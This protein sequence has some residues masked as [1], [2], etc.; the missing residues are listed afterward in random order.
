MIRRSL[1]AAS[2]RAPAWCSVPSSRSVCAFAPPAQADSSE[3]TEH[4]RTFFNAGAQAY[5]AARYADAVRRSSRR[6]SSR[7]GPQVLFSLAQAER[8]EFLDGQRCDY[9]RRA[10]AHYKEYLE[11]VPERRPPVR[12]ARGEGGARGA[13]RAASSRQPR[14]AATPSREAEAARHRLLADAGRAGFD[15]RRAAA[16]AAVL[17]RS[18]AGQASRCAS[19]PR[20]TSTPSRRSRATRASMC[21]SSLPLQEQPALVTVA[22]RTTA[23]IFV[24][25]RSSPTRR[26]A[27]RSRCRPGLHVIAIA[28][29]RQAS[30]WSQEVVLRAREAVQA[31][32]EARDEQAARRRVS[33]CSASAAR[34]R[35]TGGVFARQRA[36]AQ[37]NRAKNLETQRA[38]ENLDAERARASTTARS[39]GATRMRNGVASCLARPAARSPPAAL[40]LYLFDRP[41]VS[42]VP[43]RR[44]SPGPSR[45]RRSTLQPSASRHWRRI[46]CSARASTA[47]AMTARF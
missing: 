47:R 26:L 34:P 14:A 6:T 32:A 24:D 31:R 42:V 40:L 37:E 44:S 19:S 39:I 7:R 23:E 20:A 30:A 8:K 43:P 21:R 3:D 35:V 38:Q 10:I 1:D 25:G 36:S 15:R 12:G 28:Q 45:R 2:P 16:G 29:E 22:L 5:S 13:A 46:R 33:R 27:R 18:R 9:L 4:A 17:R 41:P 11:K